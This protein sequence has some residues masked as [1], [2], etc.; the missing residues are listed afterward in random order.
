M[1]IF[2]K[3]KN[4]S[5]VQIAYIFAK[6]QLKLYTIVRMMVI[7]NVVKKNYSGLYYKR[8]YDRKVTLLF[9]VYLTIIIYTSS[10]KALALQAT[11]VTIVTHS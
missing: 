7:I 5:V 2:K 9:S 11:F 1:Y 6:R 4:R 8:V 10:S 3:M